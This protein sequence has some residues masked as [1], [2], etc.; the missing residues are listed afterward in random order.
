MSK[1]P[2][3]KFVPR[4]YNSVK[5]KSIKTETQKKGIRVMRIFTNPVAN[6]ANGR[7]TERRK[8]IT[9]KTSR[10]AVMAMI[11]FDLSGKAHGTLEQVSLFSA[12]IHVDAI[13]KEIFVIS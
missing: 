7:N 5:A 6:S 12:K 10:T 8:K 9:L 4:R 3:P 2:M 13:K 1:F 11:C